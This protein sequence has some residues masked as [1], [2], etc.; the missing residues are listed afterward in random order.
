MYLL[1]IGR[2]SWSAPT[3]PSSPRGK[4]VLTDLVTFCWWIL[5]C[6]CNES[7]SGVFLLQCSAQCGLGQQMRTVQCL[8]Y[9]G[10]PSNECAESL[11]P[12]TMQQCESK[13]DAT[14][15]SNGDGKVTCYSALYCAA[16]QAHVW[17]CHHILIALARLVCVT[18][19]R[20][21]VC[22]HSQ[23][24]KCVVTKPTQVSV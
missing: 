16:Q 2:L 8:S 11:R 22:H 20:L 10:Q 5:S 23:E 17:A 1:M 3:L 4:M 21:A 15:I 24:E 6:M 13:C 14:P 12:T 19:C 7:Y 18:S 9:T